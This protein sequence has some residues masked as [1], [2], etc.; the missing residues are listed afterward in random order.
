MDFKKQQS[1]KRVKMFPKMSLEDSTNISVMKT[2]RETIE[3]NFNNFDRFKF[4]PREYRAHN[5]KS[6]FGH[7]YL[8]EVETRERSPEYNIEVGDES[9]IRKS[10]AKPKGFLEVDKYR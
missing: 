5:F 7:E 8:K 9:F 10:M 1:T 3:S 6:D 2:L 4:K